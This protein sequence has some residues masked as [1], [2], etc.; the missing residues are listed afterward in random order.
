MLSKTEFDGKNPDGFAVYLWALIMFG[1]ALSPTDCS[2][3]QCGI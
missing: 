2:E 3:R 1:N